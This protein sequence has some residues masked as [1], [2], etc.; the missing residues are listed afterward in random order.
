[1][2]QSTISGII[3][4]TSAALY[5][6]L[7]NDF[8]RFPSQEEE[9]KAIAFDF[10]ERWNFYNCIGAMDGKHVRIDP[11]LNAGSMYYNYKEFNSIVLLA[12]VDAQLRFIYVD[13]GAN[14][15]ACDRGIWNRSSLKAALLSNSIHIPPPS[16]LPGTEETFPFVIVGDEGF[17]LTE[18]VLLPYPGLQ[19]NNNRRKRIFNY[20]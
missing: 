9:W 16:A 13:V 7:K 10:G 18:Q 11:P 20:R 5:S 17:T 14:G 1:M 6:V 8:L 3:R 2:G 19:C 12:L 15:R 4:E